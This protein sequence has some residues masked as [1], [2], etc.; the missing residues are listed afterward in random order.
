[1]KPMKKHSIPLTI[2]RT[3]VRYSFTPTAWLQFKNETVP[4]ADGE[5]PG[6]SHSS[7]VC[8]CVKGCS[9]FGKHSGSASKG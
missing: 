4:S 1:M 6:L 9:H 7:G 5:E 8:V 3:T 2:I